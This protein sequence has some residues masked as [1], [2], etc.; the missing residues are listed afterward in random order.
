MRIFIILAEI[1][2]IYF[3]IKLLKL[4]K[5]P[6]KQILLYA[7]NPLIIIELT[8]NLHF[9]SIMIFFLILS[10]YFLAHQKNN[11]SAI[12]YG[13]SASIKLIPLIFLPSFFRVLKPAKLL[14]YY[15]LFTIS[16]LILFSPFLSLSLKDNFLQSVSLWFKSFEFNA[17]IYYILK[18]LRLHTG[19]YSFELYARIFLPVISLMTIFIISLRKNNQD[20]FKHIETFLLSLTFYYFLST[21]IHPWY[22][23]MLIILSVFTKYKYAF[24]WS[25]FIIFSYAAYQTATYNENL[26]F[27]LIEYVAV[28]V[29]FF[30]EMAKYFRRQIPVKNQ[31]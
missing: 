25:F 15:L 6:E 23:S 9:E 1:G 18:Q 31:I 8:G 24:I 13:V 17:S 11:I 19:N 12:F 3:G 22:I 10:L 7:L 29:V 27:V 16:F 2:T 26:Q 20:I 5:L 14:I 21:T 28:Y 30:Y 4:L